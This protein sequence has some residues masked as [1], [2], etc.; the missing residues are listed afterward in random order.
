MKNKR[1]WLRLPVMALLFGMTVIGVSAQSNNSGIDGIWEFPDEETIWIFEKGNLLIFDDDGEFD[2]EYSYTIRGNTLIIDEEYEYELKFSI[3][4]N[5]LTLYID[6]ETLTGRK[7]NESQSP[8]GRWIPERGQRVP[9]GFPDNLELTNDGTGIADKM[10]LK[11]K[12]ENN[13]ITIDLGVWG[14][15]SYYYII[16]KSELILTNEDYDSIK[17]TKR[18]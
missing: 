7:I 14:A 18:R 8:V 4:G 3:K 2:D 5:T 15:Y 1:L 10:G 12:A 11:W 16:Y 13:R 9:T 6:D 17:Y